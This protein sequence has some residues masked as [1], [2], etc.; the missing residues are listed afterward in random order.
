MIITI[1]AEPRSGSTNLANW[2]YFNEEFTV[3]FEPLNPLSKWFI[4]DDLSK[5]EYNTNHLLIKE[6]C[7][8]HH[9]LDDIIKISDKIILLYREDSV[10]QIESFV[11]AIRSKNWDKEYV[12]KPIDDKIFK[13]KENYFKN[14]KQ[15]FRNKYFCKG[16]FEISYE[17]LYY[18]DKFQNLLDYLELNLKNKNFP[19]GKKYRLT[20]KINKLI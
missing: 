11:S 2:F 19:I 14:L 18:R 3:L 1:L 16:Y 17:D 6:M 10:Y 12:Y 20:D 5:F 15:E 8:P 9:R 4:T 7:Y 13:D